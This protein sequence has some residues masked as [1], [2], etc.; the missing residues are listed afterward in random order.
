[1]AALTRYVLQLRGIRVLLEA[2]DLAVAY[3]PHV[4]DLRVESLPGLLVGSR[5]APLNHDNI[6]CVVEFSRVDG[7]AV[8]FRRE[9]GEQVL[10]DD[11]WPRRPSIRSR[12][13]SA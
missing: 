2:R 8:P 7:E 1:M 4:A 9:P 11:Y 13:R 3:L 10:H 12:S 6:A 5:V